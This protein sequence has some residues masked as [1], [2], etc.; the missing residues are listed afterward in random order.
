M[1]FRLRELRKQSKLTLQEL[2]NALGTS[3]QAISRYELEEREPDIEMLGKIANY[4][5]VSIDY[6]LGHETNIV[7]KDNIFTPDDY[8]KGVRNNRTI[9]VTVGEEAWLELYHRLGRA[10]IKL[11]CDIVRPVFPNEQ[12]IL[13]DIVEYS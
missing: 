2:A 8:A 5:G 1:K 6:L 11:L 13:N 7:E 9:R 4:F 12:D 3:N 10:N